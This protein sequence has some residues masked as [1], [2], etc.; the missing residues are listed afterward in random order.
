MQARTGTRM[1]P[2][3][4]A[5]SVAGL[6]PA[7]SIVLLSTLEGEVAGTTPGDDTVCDSTRPKLALE[8]RR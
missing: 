6:V 3:I 7:I 5:H 1:R 8:L 4:E 2:D